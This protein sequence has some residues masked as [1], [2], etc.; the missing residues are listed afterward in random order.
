[1]ALLMCRSCGEFVTAVGSD[2]TLEPVR[3]TC[4]ECGGTSF[5]DNR[6]DRIVDVE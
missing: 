4:P 6:S 3:S 1:M 2:E 5:R